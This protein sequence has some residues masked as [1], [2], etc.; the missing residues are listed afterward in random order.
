MNRK[1]L[2]PREV[3]GTVERSTG[4]RSDN[5]AP[6]S[7][8]A[9]DGVAI[10]LPS[11]PISPA[12]RWAAGGADG[13]DHGAHGDQ[14]ETQDQQDDAQD[15]HGAPVPWKVTR[16]ALSGGCRSGRAVMTAAARVSP[17]SSPT[18]TAPTSSARRCARRAA[19]GGPHRHPGGVAGPGPAGR[20]AC[21]SAQPDTLTRRVPRDRRSDRAEVRGGYRIRTGVDG[22]AGRCLASQPTRHRCRA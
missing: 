6:H 4:D 17:A 18:G 7:R 3:V 12:A 19:R 2:P 20:S 11:A 1:S 16:V 8:W 10:G 13:G 21:R 22:F 5:S 15:V 14:G 9:A